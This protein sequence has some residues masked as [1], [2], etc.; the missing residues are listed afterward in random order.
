MR[1]NRVLPPDETI[2]YLFAQ[3]LTA[4]E[5]AKRYWVEV[6]S[7]NHHIRR[8]GLRKKY[9]NVRVKVDALERAQ[10]LAEVENRTV[11]EIVSR[12]IMEMEVT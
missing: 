3:G 1:G 10:R 5:I 6:K 4:S 7:V 2:E 11:S 9:A 8:M 12:S